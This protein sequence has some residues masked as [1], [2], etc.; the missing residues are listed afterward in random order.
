[1]IRVTISTVTDRGVL[2]QWYGKFEDEE[3]AM[4]EAKANR[5]ERDWRALAAKAGVLIRVDKEMIG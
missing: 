3:P 5:Y 2:P 1:M 4:N